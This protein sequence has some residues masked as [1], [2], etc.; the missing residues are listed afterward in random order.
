MEKK[1][2]RT[3]NAS[4]QRRKQR[5]YIY[6]SPLH[7]KH[8]FFSVNL[9]KDLRKKYSRRNITLRTGDTVKIMRGEFKKKRGK[10]MVVDTAKFRVY[11][12]GVQRVKKDGTKVNV[13][14]KPSK[15]QIVELNLDDKKRIKSMERKK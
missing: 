14:F 1:F 6:H 5:K 3:W 7:L 10:I 11:I 12:E 9:S 15:L 2:S 4:V 8:R 13:P